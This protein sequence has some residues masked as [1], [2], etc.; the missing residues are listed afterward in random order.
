MCGA[1]GASMADSKKVWRVFWSSQYAGISCYSGANVGGWL[2][3][4][5]SLSNTFWWVPVYRRYTYI[6]QKAT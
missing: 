4:Q 1:V 2:T 6:P 5:C 3:D